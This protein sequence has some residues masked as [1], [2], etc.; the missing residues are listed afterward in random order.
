MGRII[1]EIGLLILHFECSNPERETTM[2]GWVLKLVKC[3]HQIHNNRCSCSGN[4]VHTSFSAASLFVA[5]NIYFSSLQSH[6][7]APLLTPEVWI[8]WLHTLSMQLE[9]SLSCSVGC[10]CAVRRHST[11]VQRTCGRCNIYRPQRLC[12]THCWWGGTFMT[13]FHK[14]QQKSYTHTH[15]FCT[16]SP[17][18]V[19][20]DVFLFFLNRAEWRWKLETK[21]WSL[22]LAHSPTT[23]SW[24]W[25]VCPKVKRHWFTPREWFF[26]QYTA[27]HKPTKVTVNH[28]NCL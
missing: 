20:G 13:P 10:V 4:I 18:D 8:K 21:T 27:S 16:K 14:Q 11:V 9:R 25:A 26:S 15:R 12:V 22:K 28:S 1:M 5:L 2:P 24:H 3:G 23:E 7:D 17:L 19:L 6:A